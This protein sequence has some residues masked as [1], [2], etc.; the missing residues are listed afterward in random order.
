M[1]KD[2][3][4]VELVELIQRSWERHRPFVPKWAELTAQ[5][6]PWLFDKGLFP[7][8]PS[9]LS[10]PLS[11]EERKRVVVGRSSFLFASFS[12]L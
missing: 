7:L 9:S 6:C 8:E 2:M 11:F 3:S 10:L 4:L 12:F 1:T 5:G